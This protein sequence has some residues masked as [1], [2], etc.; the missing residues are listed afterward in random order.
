MK[1]SLFLLF[2]ILISGVSALCEE[3]QIDI[4]TASAEELDEIVYIGPTRAEQIMVL[5]PFDSIDDLIKVSGIG[6]IYLD[7][8]KEQ[9]LACINDVEED[10]EPEEEIEKEEQ[11]DPINESLLK[12]TESIELQTINLNPQV[13]KTDENKEKVSKGYAVYGFV[14]FCI[15][16]AILFII[17][18]RKYKNEF[19]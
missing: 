1:I 9:G 16:I 18:N 14:V 2:I 5:R 13:I 11:S 12:K 19:E 6:E 17:K 10:K 3:G 7:A 4:N 15:F 8:I